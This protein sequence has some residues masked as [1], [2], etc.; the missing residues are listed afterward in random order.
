MDDQRAATEA[1]F[2]AWADAILSKPIPEGTE[3]FHFNLYEGE[4]SVGVQLWGTEAFE[5]GDN[6]ETGYW[7]ADPTFSSG[8]DLFRIPFSVAGDAWPEWLRTA[9]DFVKSYIEGGRY[10]GVMRSRKGVSI[11]FVDGDMYVVWQ[12]DA[13]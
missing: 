6:P 11:G 8:E 10:S 13:V 3:A 2:F 1:R 12:A 9:T 7:P 5:P 4:N